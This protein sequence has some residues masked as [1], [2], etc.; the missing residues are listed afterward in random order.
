MPLVPVYGPN[1]VV[2]PPLRGA[3]LVGPLGLRVSRTRAGGNTAP[4]PSD[5]STRS[6]FIRFQF[7]LVVPDV[8]VV[9]NHM[10]ASV[11]RTNS[12]MPDAAVKFGPAAATGLRIIWANRPLPLMVFCPDVPPS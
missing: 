3:P 9:D 5:L 4:V 10:D 8:R 11:P 2:V 7:A 6:V 1:L 12:A